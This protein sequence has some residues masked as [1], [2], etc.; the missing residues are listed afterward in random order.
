MSFKVGET[1]D[2]FK[3]FNNHTWLAYSKSTN[4]VGLIPTFLLENPTK[5]FGDTLP[6]LRDTNKSKFLNFAKEFLRIKRGDLLQ[7][8]KTPH[9]YIWLA[10]HGKNTGYILK[11]DVIDTCIDGFVCGDVCVP[12]KRI[13]QGG[14]QCQCGN[15]TIFPFE[16]S[17]ATFCCIH[18]KDSCVEEGQD[19]VICPGGKIQENLVPCHGSCHGDYKYCINIAYLQIHSLVRILIMNASLPLTC[20]REWTGVGKLN[21]VTKIFSVMI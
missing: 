9:P 15:G 19:A 5:N 1:V 6:A 14:F 11:G 3:K 20:V 13:F 18:P 17:F 10:T 4:K 7:I 2:I 8:K 21:I 16:D 12:F